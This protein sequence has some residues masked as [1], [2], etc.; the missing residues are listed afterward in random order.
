MSRHRAYVHAARSLLR[1]QRREWSASL[2]GE[3]SLDRQPPSA[4][5][6][7]LSEFDADIAVVY[8]GLSDVAAAFGGDPYE[9]LRDALF[10][11][12]DAVLTPGFTFSFRQT[13]TVNLDRTLPETGMFGR[14][15]LADA[16]S[17][18]NDPV[19]S[20]LGAGSFAFETDETDRSYGPDGYWSELHDRD[21]LYLNVGTDR[22]RCSAFH[23]AEVRHDVPYVSEVTLSG[24]IERNGSARWVTH[25]IP[26]DDHYRRFARRKVR[27]ELGDDLIDVS[28]GGV[29]IQ[30]C[31]AGAIDALLDDRLSEDA[32][33]LVT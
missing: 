13:G 16:E 22:F 33:Y 29:R 6:G 20:L 18:T 17:R 1:E 2:G 11:Q 15:F 28:V 7:A 4:L 12:F 32:Y 27:S 30:G 21:V 3:P 10:A 14:R 23:C 31:R 24:R 9:R 19:F 25:R 5:R 26:T 8:A